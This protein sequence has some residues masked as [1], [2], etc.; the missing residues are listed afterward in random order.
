MN[1][2]H[3]SHWRDCHSQFCIVG[4]LANNLC[5][6]KFPSISVLDGDLNLWPCTIYPFLIC[7]SKDSGQ[8]IRCFFIYILYSCKVVCIFDSFF[9]NITFMLHALQS[10]GQNLSLLEVCSRNK[11]LILRQKQLHRSKTWWTHIHKI[12]NYTQWHL[13]DSMLEGGLAS[14]SI[15]MSSG[16]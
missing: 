16:L 10:A 3:R 7:R 5:T 4:A 11:Q 6:E 8:S 13:V 15:Y 2:D 12:K 14:L 1:S 9:L